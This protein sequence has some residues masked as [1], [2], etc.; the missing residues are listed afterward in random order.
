MQTLFDSFVR[1]FSGPFLLSRRHFFRFAGF[2]LFPSLFHPFLVFFKIPRNRTT[3]SRPLS[4][5]S[6]PY[7]FPFQE[8]PMLLERFRSSF[9]SGVLLHVKCSL[10]SVH[11]VKLSIVCPGNVLSPPPQD[12]EFPRDQLLPTLSFS[13]NASK[14][15]AS[16]PQYRARFQR[17]RRVAV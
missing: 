14:G 3:P 2:Y 11:S 4:P 7:Y 5:L 17:L 6:P 12:S 1:L 15:V 8:P 10:S 9:G 13:N 16:F